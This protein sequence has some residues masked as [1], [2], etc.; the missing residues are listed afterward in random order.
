MSKIKVNKRKIIVFTVI[1]ILLLAFILKG[2]AYMDIISFGFNQNRTRYN[3][4]MYGGIAA[5]QVTSTTKAKLGWYVTGLGP[6]LSQPLIISPKELGIN[7]SQP[8]VI[9]FN[10]NNLYAYESISPYSKSLYDFN[11]STSPYT[12]TPKIVPNSNKKWG[13]LPVY[14]SS[15]VPANPSGSHPTYYVSP[16]GNKYIAAGSKD[17]Y[18][19][20]Y[21]I[22]NGSPVLKVRINTTT[23]G[24][25]DIVSA[26]LMMRWQGYNI[27]VVGDGNGGQVA[28][29]YFTDDF[30]DV[31]IA[32][33]T[34][35]TT[36]TRISSSA[37]P[38]NA[39][40]TSPET[41]FIIGTTH[42]PNKTADGYLYRIR[43][44]DLF[45]V[46]SS[47]TIS[48]RT[49]ILKL[50]STGNGVKILQ[51]TLNIIGYSL[52]EDGQ[53]GTRTQAA[54]KDFQSKNGLTVDGIVGPQTWQKL[55]S[56]LTRT[57]IRPIYQ[58][59]YAWGINISKAYAGAGIGIPA[60]FSVDGSNA[61]FTD[62]IGGIYKIN[63]IFSSTLNLTV[64][65]NLRNTNNLVNHSPAVDDRYLYIPYYYSDS[66]K[67]H[68]KIVVLDKNNLNVIK[69]IDFSSSSLKSQLPNSS[70]YIV[71]SAVSVGADR[72][73]ANVGNY[74]VTIK[75][76]DWTI[77]GDGT[78]QLN[79]PA[80]G[81]VSIAHGLVATETSDGIY[82]Y[83]LAKNGIDLAITNVN[84]IGYME[85]NKNYTVQV[86]VSLGNSSTSIPA[87]VA[88]YDAGSF[89]F[90]TVITG[91]PVRLNTANA[92]ASAQITLSPNS[93]QTVNLSFTGT[94]SDRNL[95]AV[96]QPNP[97]SNPD[98][99]LQYWDY[100]Q[101][102]N[103]RQFTAPAKRLVDLYVT[104]LNA[105]TSNMVG[106]QTY[107]CSVVV[108]LQNASFISGYPVTGTLKIYDAAN[109]SSPFKTQ[110][111]SFTSNTT[112]T[113]SF[114]YTGKSSDM[115]LVAEISLAS[116]DK[117]YE[118]NL[119]NNKIQTLVKANNG[120]DL[121]IASINPGTTYV[122]PDETYT[123]SVTVGLQKS[124]AFPVNGVVKVY[125]KADS[126]VFLTKSVQF[127]S[128]STQTFSFSYP[129][130]NTDITLVAEIQLTDT[131]K[132]D[133]DLSNNKKEV[134]VPYSSE[135]DKLRGTV[136]ISKT[137]QYVFT[138]KHTREDGS[139]CDMTLNIS[140]TFNKKITSIRAVHVINRYQNKGVLYVEPYSVIKNIGD[141]TG[142]AVM[143]FQYDKPGDENS[144][145]YIYFTAEDGK[146]A[147]VQL[148]IPV[149]GFYADSKF[150]LPDPQ[151]KKS[152]QDNWTVIFK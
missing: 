110:T 131:N 148:K 14:G 145:L 73:Y 89:N 76:S 43:F 130:K 79:A 128:N 10:G 52:V 44:S 51:E 150:N 129:G 109:P 97:P 28:I 112:Q 80:T 87:T 36:Y 138:N 101:T 3:Y 26:P 2:L 120:V 125:D 99:Y 8:I 5:T 13:P 136:T 21:Q 50:G 114:N 127:N 61:Y 83:Y 95:I 111:V 59:N 46:I 58:W 104:N 90:N 143:K 134:T 147:E 141:V 30:S 4:E 133:L 132:Y 100:N 29:G 91:D 24:G 149:N 123:G 64:N 54:V 74:L 23:R 9:A 32:D 19:F 35:G 85:P 139:V 7:A 117:Y 81:E 152:E 124:Y 96:V 122:V 27:V 108:G 137:P 126:S 31:R 12:F 144:T 55:G 15:T 34:L 67:Q 62:A 41:G 115:I 48:S 20:I 146:T 102:N 70:N 94:S 121:Y 25:T 40:E 119:S 33:I 60:S 88:L 37:A 113:V 42:E 98:S 92:V 116:A 69:Q 56:K 39:G 53:F 49:D 135:M 93:S 22:I 57:Y 18:V 151:W 105:G 84:P 65:G 66:S 103:T 86:T 47:S 68:G 107:T 77:D 142:S 106:G 140:Y 38:V 78:I 45:N 63:N 118:T 75:K 17:G 16:N 71:Y 6:S 82:V 1:G 72:I 11:T